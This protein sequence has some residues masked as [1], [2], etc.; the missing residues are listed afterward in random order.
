N[1]EYNVSMNS[2]DIESIKN[3]LSHIRNG[4][5][6][7]LISRLL[8]TLEI[9]RKDKKEIRTKIIDW[10]IKLTMSGGLIYMVISSFF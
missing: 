7:D 8:D 4:F 6:D 1:I 5:K 2:K 9:Q 3:E 10:I